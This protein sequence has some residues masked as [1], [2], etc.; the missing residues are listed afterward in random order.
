[1]D[2]PPLPDNRGKRTSWLDING[3]RIRFL[4]IDEIKRIQSNKPYKAIYLQ[5]LELLDESRIELRLGY[6]IIGKKPRV[7]GKW[8][9][10]QYATLMPTN[11]F[12]AVVQEAEKRGWI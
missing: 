12:R 4:I 3:K 11:D 7:K 1:M 10:G 5:K 9:W 2:Y 8:V 6:Y